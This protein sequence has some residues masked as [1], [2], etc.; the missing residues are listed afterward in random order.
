MH[1]IAVRAVTIGPLAEET[2]H[3]RRGLCRSDNRLKD[4]R[5]FLR[6]APTTPGRYGARRRMLGVFAAP[7]SADSAKTGTWGWCPH[8]QRPWGRKRPGC[9]IHCSATCRHRGWERCLGAGFLRRIG[10]RFCCLWSADRYSGI[11]GH[12]RPVRREEYCD[13]LLLQ[14]QIHLQWLSVCRREFTRC[15]PGFFAGETT[16]E[17]F[18]GSHRG[19]GRANARPQRSLRTTN[20]TPHTHRALRTTNRTLPHTHRA[21]DHQQD[22]A[23]YPSGLRTTNRTLCPYPSGLRTTNGTLPHTHRRPTDHQPDAAP[24]PSGPADHQ[25]GTLHPPI[26]SRTA[27]RTLPHT[28]GLR[29]TNG[30]L[31]HTHRAYGPPTGRCGRISGCSITVVSGRNA[32]RGVPELAGS[33]ADC[34]ASNP[35]QVTATVQDAAASQIVASRSTAERRS[36]R[37]GRCGAIRLERRGNAPERP[38]KRRSGSAAWLSSPPNPPNDAATDQDAAASPSSRS[39]ANDAAADQDAAARNAI[40]SG[41]NARRARPKRQSGSAA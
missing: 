11:P 21:T 33:A 19:R 17:D 40:V 18:D 34:V 15:L 5:G 4:R 3:R 37:S 12:Y 2:Q 25:P 29:T 28:I 39:A 22:A 14:S 7:A 23:P 27:D 16:K 1:E 41:R 31:P 6:R 8:R 32:A 38:K 9:S 26:S 35:Q 13:P 10:G 30:T 20:W 24:C 36:N